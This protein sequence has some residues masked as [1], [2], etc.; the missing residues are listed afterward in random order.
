MIKGIAKSIAMKNKFHKKMSPI[1]IKKLKNIKV[2]N[3]KNVLLKLTQNI[4]A[5]HFDDIFCKNK[6][7]SKHGKV[8]RKYLQMSKQLKNLL[9]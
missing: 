1:K 3:Y 7:S 6:I 9:R 4:K 8:L 5:N 2:K